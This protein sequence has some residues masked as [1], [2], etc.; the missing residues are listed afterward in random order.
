MRNALDRYKLR[1]GASC[2]E[3]AGE[4]QKVGKAIHDKPSI[5]FCITMMAYPIE[6]YKWSIACGF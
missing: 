2:Y 4:T 6:K 5:N 3:S 1:K